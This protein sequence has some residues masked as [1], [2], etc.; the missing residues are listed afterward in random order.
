MTDDT[1][2]CTACLK[3]IPIKLFDVEKS[4]YV[5]KICHSCRLEQI[6][7]A[8]L[9]KQSKPKICTELKTCVRC[10]LIKKSSEFNKL[11]ISDDGLD[12]ECR[13]CLKENRFRKKP[14]NCIVLSATLMCDK[15][16]MTKP[17]TSFKST[18]RSKTGY[19]KTCNDCRKPKEWNKEK[20]KA[21][22]KKYV[23]NNPDKLRAKWKRKGD[24]ISNKIRDR[25]N[26]RI[27][28]AFKSIRSYKS[29][30]TTTYLGC[31]IEYLKKWFEFQFSD[32]INWKNYG[33]WHIDHVL[34]CSSFD[35]SIVEE[36][37]KCFNWKNLRPCLKEENLQKG[38][39]II[40]SV[41]EKQNELV[42]NFI[43]VNPL[44]THPGDRDEGAV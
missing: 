25:L 19:F 43:K 44:P 16:L 4:G 14:E 35:L 7:R 27:S 29:N 37:Y 36:Q 12:K 39:K 23:Q 13:D 1:K 18:A 32:K 34:P 31:S 9:E 33:E 26:H 3:I 5:R 2:E 6:K 42:N 41:I 38:D 10:N 21:S 22:E 17:C 15:C 20:Q 30:T 11:S 28:D 40:E 8:R 24:K